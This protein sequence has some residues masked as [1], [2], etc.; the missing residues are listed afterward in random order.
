L[1]VVDVVLGVVAAAPVTPAVC[2]VPVDEVEVA[3]AAGV[4]VTELVGVVVAVLCVVVA[5][6]TPVVAA[7]G[8]GVVA[9]AAW[10]ALACSAESN[11][12][13]SGAWIDAAAR[14]APA[15]PCR[16]STD[17][18]PAITMPILA[19]SR[20]IRCA[21]DSCETLVRSSSFRV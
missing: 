13:A 15:P 16:K 10:T 9:A 4:V 8:A 3:A 18:G 7:V 6:D 11:M 20:S 1:G 21:L 14:P 5:V 19:A 2:V 17:V 12:T